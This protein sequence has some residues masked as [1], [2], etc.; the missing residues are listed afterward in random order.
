MKQHYKQIRQKVNSEHDRI[1]HKAL[2]LSTQI[3]SQETMPHII[4]SHQTRPNPR[5]SMPSDYWRITVTIPLLDS[6]ICEMETRFSAEKRAHYE[7]CAL[8]PIGIID[9]DEQELCTI[10]KSK[11]KHLLP[12]E[13]DLDSE[14]ARWKAHCNEYSESLK[15]KSI[16]H[17]LSEDADPIFFP[18]IR[19]LLCILAVLPIGS[20]EAERSFSCLRQIHTWLHAT[21]TDERLGSLGVL[22]KQ[23][24]TYF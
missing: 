12:A 8:M 11:W 22:A 10:L 2:D 6:I 17:L 5:V 19:E 7:L 1:Y 18:N 24:S 21:M 15:E 9:K 23:E 14:L 13:D 16:T 3:G 20:A 4:G